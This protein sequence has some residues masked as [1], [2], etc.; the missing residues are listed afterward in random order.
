MTGVCLG[1]KTTQ[2]QFNNDIRVMSYITENRGHDITA[3]L[4]HN[5]GYKDLGP[6]NPRL[7][8]TNGYLQVVLFSVIV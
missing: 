1:V 7:Y 2:K 3:Y 5:L 4:L 8:S 6:G